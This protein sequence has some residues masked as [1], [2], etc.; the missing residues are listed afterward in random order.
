MDCVILAAGEGTRMKSACPKVLHELGG[1]SMIQHLLDAINPL[2]L[3]RI[4]L[5]V[6]YKEGW[7]REE[8]SDRDVGF[9]TQEEQ[10]GTGHALKQAREQI[11]SDKVLVLP[12]DIPLLKRSSLENFLKQSRKND[13]GFS[14]LSVD[15]EDPSGYGRIVRRDGGGVSR[16]VEEKDATEKERSIKE[17]NTGIYLFNNTHLLWEGLEGLENDNAQG[18]FYLTDLVEYYIGSGKQVMAVK[19]DGSEQFLGVNTRADLAEASRIL[20]NRRQSSSD[21][22]R[23]SANS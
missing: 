22:G 14:L 9:V 23:S 6:G 8:L 19:V 18:E 11:K 15:R 10:L 16:V 13:E 3:S 1:T 21:E 12:G 5:V 4:T 17:I 2:E 20:Q 7:V